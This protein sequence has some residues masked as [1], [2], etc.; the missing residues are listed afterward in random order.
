[1]ETTTTKSF[2]HLYPPQKDIYLPPK[3]KNQFLLSSYSNTFGLE[4]DE[5]WGPLFIHAISVPDHSQ[6]L[7]ITFFEKSKSQIKRQK[8]EREEDREDIYPIRGGK[9]SGPHRYKIL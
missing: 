2:T 6:S 1:M 9:E 5:F 3:N 7:P 8:T 4:M